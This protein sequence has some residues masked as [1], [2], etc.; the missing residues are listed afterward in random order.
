MRVL[1]LLAGLV[2]I[3]S[4]QVLAYDGFKEDFVTCTQGMDKSDIV[5]ACTRLINNASVENAMIGMLYGVRASNND[6]RAQNCADARKSLALADDDA[7]KALSQKLIAA[8][9]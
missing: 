5:E 7:I 2:M 6:D 4:T 9:C 8:N 1:S 3:A